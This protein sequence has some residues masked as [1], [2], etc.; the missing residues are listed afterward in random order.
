MHYQLREKQALKDPRSQR[1]NIYQYKNTER[2]QKYIVLKNYGKLSHTPLFFCAYIYTCIKITYNIYLFQEFKLNVKDLLRNPA[3]PSQKLIE[4]MSPDAKELHKMY[5]F[6]YLL[7][8][9]RVF[10]SLFC[11][12]PIAQKSFYVIE[13]IVTY[14]A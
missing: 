1:L 2:E 8:F 9:L 14:Q 12:P 3:L 13:M 5:V 7:P 10:F 4:K 6:D 11:I